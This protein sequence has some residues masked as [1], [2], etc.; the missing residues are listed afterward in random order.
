MWPVTAES[1]PS[2]NR[3]PMS[4]MQIRVVVLVVLA[5]VVGVVLWLVLGHSSKGKHHGKTY[6]TIGPIAFSSK[7][8][9][10]E[11]HFIHTRFFW[12]GPQQGDTYE[13]TRDRNGY[14]FVRY[15]P[16][17]IHPGAKGAH[18]LIVVTYPFPGGYQALK[19]QAKSNALPGPDQSIVFQ[20]PHDK[21]S[22]LMAFP[23]QDY[24][25]EVFDP[26]PAVALATARS[27]KIKLIG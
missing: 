21:K 10:Q 2:V 24:Q 15:L 13:F 4:S 12:A 5:V 14:L 3:Q 25:I 22:V 9:K 17:G 18:Y 20:R 16:H 11:S 8:L 26:S 6:K 27:G 1:T 23:G 19:H 7:N